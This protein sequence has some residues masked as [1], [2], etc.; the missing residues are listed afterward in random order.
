MLP[1]TPLPVNTGTF[2]RPR[3]NKQRQAYSADELE[4][5]DEMEND[6]AGYEGSPNINDVEEQ[7]RSH[8]DHKFSDVTSLHVVARMQEESK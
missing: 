6:V 8:L 1:G 4:A 3:K 5:D 7:S 2:T